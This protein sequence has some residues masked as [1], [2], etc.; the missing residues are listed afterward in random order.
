[1]GFGSFVKGGVKGAGRVAE[2]NAAMVGAGLGLV[3]AG[4][5]YWLD[6]VLFDAAASTIQGLAIHNAGALAVAGVAIA[7]GAGLGLGTREAKNATS[8]ALGWCSFHGG[9]QEDT[10]EEGLPLRVRDVRRQ[11]YEA[12][13]DQPGQ[14]GE[15]RPTTPRLG[16]S[17]E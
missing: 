10:L 17:G 7:G 8:M 14:E 12:T 3:A 1:M 13:G 15:S 9:Q 4:S 16:G 5:L 11:G 6:V 2:R